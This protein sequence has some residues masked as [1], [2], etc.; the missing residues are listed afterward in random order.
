[1]A[2]TTNEVGTIGQM[3]QNRKNKQRIGVLESRNEKFKTLMMRDSKG[4]SFT[5]NYSTFKSDWRKYD[6]EQVAQTSTQVEEKKVKEKQAEKKVEQAEKKVA[7]PEKRDKAQK[8]AVSSEDV[9]EAATAMYEY[10]IGLVEKSKENI[11]VR[12]GR[13]GMIAL[14]RGHKAIAEIW[15]N[16]KNPGKFDVV[17]N[18]EMEFSDKVGTDVSKEVMKDWKLKNKYTVS[19]SSPAI[20]EILAKYSETK[21][22]K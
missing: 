22:D 13:R 10:A 15:V 19:K 18:L 1:M 20:K 14:R 3:Y 8:S 12:I 21:E 5:I 7:K 16:R 9:T 6:G 2:Q 17:T 4:D 11:T